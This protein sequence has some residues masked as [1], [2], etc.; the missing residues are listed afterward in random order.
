MERKWTKGPWVAGP[1]YRSI[2]SDNPTVGGFSLEEMRHES[3][4]FRKK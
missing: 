1:R 4:T 3:T 2:I